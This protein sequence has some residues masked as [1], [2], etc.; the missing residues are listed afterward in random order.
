MRVCR[1]PFLLFCAVLL[2]VLPCAAQDTCA[3]PP[4]WLRV[5]DPD[6]FIGPRRADLAEFSE[7]R[8]REEYAILDDA[9]LNAPLR[10]IG[11][12]LLKAVPGAPPI[13]WALFELPSLNAFTMPG[14][15]IY[16]AR[17]T[18]AFAQSEDELAAIMAHELGHAVTRQPETELTAALRRA[19][20][21]TAL[22]SRQEVF[23]VY[24]RMIENER[25]K[26][27][28]TRG[29]MEKDQDIADAIGV[30]L[31]ARAGYDPHA[32]AQIW[33][34]FAGTEGKMG[35]AF[36][37]FFGSTPPEQ[38]RLREMSKLA[39]SLPA[40]CNLLRR[41]ENASGDFRKWQAEVVAYSL[42]R[43]ESLP[44]LI[45]KMA[46]DSPIRGDVERLGFSPDGKYIFAQDGAGVFV[47]SREPLQVLFNVSADDIAETHFSA[48]SRELVFVTDDLRVERWD[49]T[50]RQR[51]WVREMPVREPCWSK[52][53]SPDGALL[54]CF[55]LEGNLELTETA[56]A[57]VTFAKK[58][59]VR[60]DFFLW[61]LIA[62]LQQGG[63]NAVNMQ[64]SPDGRYFLAAGFEQAVAYDVMKHA[65][66]N[67]PG[68]VKGMTTGGFTFTAD[69]NLVGI[70][71]QQQEN[72]GVVRFPG[73]E[74]VVKRPLRGRLGPTAHGD[75]VLLRPI[76]KYP[77][78]ALN[79]TDGKIPAGSRTAPMDVYDDVYVIETK[80]GEVG[81][82]RIGTPSPL[83]TV[84]LPRTE[85]SEVRAAA[86]SSDGRWLAISERSRGAVWDL[87]SN[88]RRIHVHGFE[89]AYFEGSRL[90]SKLTLAPYERQTPPGKDEPEDAPERVMASIDMA[91]PEQGA[92]WRP[93][94]PEEGIAEQRGRYLVR[95]RPVQKGKLFEAWVLE[96]FDVITDRLLWSRPL[97]TGP[98]EIP[99][100][101]SDEG[102]V[103]LVW[104][105]DTGPAKEA[106]KHDAALAGRRKA[107]GDA[108]R[109]YYVEVLQTG[110]GRPLQKMLVE[111]G[112]GSF[113]IR[114]VWSAPGFLILRDSRKRVLFYSTETG[115]QKAHFFG[116][117]GSVLPSVGAIL[118]ESEIGT[119]D[120][121]DLK[122]LAK[123]NTLR[124]PAGLAFATLDPTG[125]QLLLLDRDQTLYRLDVQALAR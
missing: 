12:R 88:Q 24:N 107:L 111:T 74:R 50:T 63:P 106:V 7:Q 97:G 27:G 72:S 83:A 39:A 55:T 77:V 37:N 99:E 100:V 54:A 36:S 43:Q 6:I 89:G 60:F 79:L 42:K 75:Y 25:V 15:R 11:E 14:G 84:A 64:F 57:N 68:S 92:A 87:K 109:D 23:D 59:F 52:A 58:P 114:H 1:R 96:V 9:A 13:E 16:I 117:W 91:T 67:L 26:P 66:I 34:R 61:F 70:S 103:S 69:G 93:L 38:K 110:S 33:D 47:L 122:T 118:V 123:R 94:G 108:S 80:S 95:K 45:S 48:D 85:L 62:L 44:G 22:N 17:K 115:E 53:L 5:S 101:Y 18:V 90:F 49:V 10:R 98:A 41:A 116:R 20:G 78:G 81:L 30:Y 31:L 76:E 21:V 51:Q 2:F 4:A 19:L 73:G 29:R 104:W 105:A 35:N 120:V 32:Y 112:K 86:L 65:Q 113:A 8:L 40:E 71:R 102:T 125:K 3:I 28:S 56:D 119:L 121:Y 124:L 46:L 82:Y